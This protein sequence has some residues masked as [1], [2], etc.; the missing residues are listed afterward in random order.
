MPANALH[1]L[2]EEGPAECNSR[3][4]ACRVPGCA[5]EALGRLRFCVVCER[6]YEAVTA[7]RGGLVEALC[8]AL[9]A[10]GDPLYAA[11]G[12]RRKEL[13]AHVLAHLEEL[14]TIDVHVPAAAVEDFV[15]ELDAR[16][17]EAR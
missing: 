12:A 2:P 3:A 16:A 14:D 8:A 4:S 10:L 11:F 15:A 7:H 17:R 13:G 6:S 9:A 1:L 5:A